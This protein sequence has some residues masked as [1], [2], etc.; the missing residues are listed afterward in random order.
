MKLST[1]D[2]DLFFKL[3]WSVQTYINLNLEIIPGIDTVGEY[4]KLPSSEK[5]PVRDALYDNIELVDVYLEDNPQRLFPEELEIIQS[6]KKF[7]RGDYFIE[8]LLKKYA[9]FIGDEQVY[10]VL[11]LHEALKD[12]FPSMRL[13]YYAKAVLLPFKSKVV[14]DGLIQGY[15]VSFGGGIK[16]TLRE[17][18]MAAKQ[19][20][21]IIESFDPKRQVEK[22]V[23]DKKAIKDYGPTI[24]E[25]SR[26]AQ[27]LRSRRGAPAVHSPAFSLVKASVDFTKLAVD[28][29][30]DFDELWK[31]LKKVERALGKVEKV[32]YRAEYY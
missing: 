6:W 11:A 5:L 18:Y 9:I 26:Q 31:A 27:K 32:L 30:D 22:T 28:T 10:G 8:R 20:G 14:Y 24:D 29:P 21:R 23:S 7:K 16:S 19:E 12:I 13:P 25:I 15:A 2:A 4:R 3:M 1:Q 17:T